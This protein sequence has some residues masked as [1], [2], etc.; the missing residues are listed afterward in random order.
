MVPSDSRVRA[1]ACPRLRQEG[2][3]V[4]SA[5]PEACVAARPVGVKRITG[6]SVGVTVSRGQQSSRAIRRV[7]ERPW[8]RIKCR[9]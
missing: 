2:M 7:P 1:S 9:R 5:V 4:E 8:P 3:A 6:L